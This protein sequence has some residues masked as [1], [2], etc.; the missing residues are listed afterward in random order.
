[1]TK[2]GW[3]SAVLFFVQAFFFAVSISDFSRFAESARSIAYDRCNEA[4]SEARLACLDVAALAGDEWTLSIYLCWA[5]LIIGS[6]LTI[7]GVVKGRRDAT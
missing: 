5:G 3:I 2:L 7:A 4:S 1:M 6:A